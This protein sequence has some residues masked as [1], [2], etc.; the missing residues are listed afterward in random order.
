MKEGCPISPTL[1]LLYCDILLRETK[2]RCPGARPYV[3]L[4]AQIKV[5]MVNFN[6]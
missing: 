2:E 6:F 5:N 1:F 4:V 3:S